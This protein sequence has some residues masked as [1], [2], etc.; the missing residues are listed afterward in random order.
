MIFYVMSLQVDL[1][2]RCSRR[3]TW[4]AGLRRT[5]VPRRVG[6]HCLS[7]RRLLRLRVCILDRRPR[8]D[9]ASEVGVFLPG[10]AG[11]G[12][13]RRGRP[14]RAGPPGRVLLGKGDHPA[15]LS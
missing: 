11:H 12:G 10:A 2:H 13:G 1:L 15:H 4:M 6:E 3:G 14:A 9:P 8:A 7:R 5:F